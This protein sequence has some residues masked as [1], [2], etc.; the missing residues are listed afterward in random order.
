MKTHGR[1]EHR[2]EIRILKSLSPKIKAE[3]SEEVYAPIFRQV[4]AFR[5]M[6]HEGLGPVRAVRTPSAPRTSTTKIQDHRTTRAC[7][8][9]L[10]TA[11]FAHIETH[12]T[13]I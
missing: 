5:S 4:R 12:D 2:S 9:L 7:H 10:Y 1:D 11:Q 8:H 6:S 3:V 13:P